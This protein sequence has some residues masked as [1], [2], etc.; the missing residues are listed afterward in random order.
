VSRRHGEPV[1]VI[2]RDDEPARFVWRDRQ[3]QVRE[4]LAH[5]TEAGRWWLA[6]PARALT[7]GESAGGSAGGSAGAGTA[8]PPLAPIPAAP[9]WAQRAVPAGG[10]PTVELGA[11][12]GP[13]VR[14]TA[15]DD[16][17]REWW[18][19]EADTAPPPADGE[20]RGAF[21]GVY[22]LCFDWTRGDW[23]LVRVLD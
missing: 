11:A 18:R 10:E 13:A 7:A 23:R 6:A 15:V 5:W 2:R 22:D 12:A 4:V 21:R 9:K 16:G 8:E 1:A 3:Y 14:P 20:E 17:E 19:V